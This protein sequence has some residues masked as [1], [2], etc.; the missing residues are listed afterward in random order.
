[1]L[2]PRKTRFVNSLVSVLC[3]LLISFSCISVNSKSPSDQIKF[4]P[5]PIN[6]STVLH[7]SGQEMALLDSFQFELTHRNGVGSPVNGFLLTEATGLIEK[8][9]KIHIIATML[10]GNLALQ[11]ELITINQDSLIRNPLT[12]KWTNIEPE[13][14]Q[15]NFFEP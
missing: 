9:D 8:P 15:I 13:F 7:R 12:N 1:M 6:P 5:T 14:S 4:R 10:L 3:G 11:G 2:F